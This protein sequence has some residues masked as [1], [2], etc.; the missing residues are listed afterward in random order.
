MLGLMNYGLWRGI[1]RA[2]YGVPS[3]VFS[4]KRER[5]GCVTTDLMVDITPPS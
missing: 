3:S 2:G 4:L 5:P 1:R